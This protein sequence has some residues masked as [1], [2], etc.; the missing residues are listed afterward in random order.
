M[1]IQENEWQQIKDWLNA[2][3][4]SANGSKTH[5][6]VLL[7]GRAHSCSKKVFVAFTKHPSTGQLTLSLRH[8]SV[9]GRLLRAL[10]GKYS[11]YAN[12]ILLPEHREQLVELIKAPPV[13]NQPPSLPPRPPET[14]PASKTSFTSFA[15]RDLLPQHPAALLGFI[16]EKGGT[17]KGHLF[18]ATQMAYIYVFGDKKNVTLKPPF[19][20]RETWNE[21]VNLR[22]RMRSL[23]QTDLDRLKYMV[24]DS[25]AVVLFGEDK[26]LSY[27]QDEE[28]EERTREAFFALKEVGKLECQGGDFSIHLDHLLPNL[29]A[30]HIQERGGEE[31]IKRD[32]Q[33]LKETQCTW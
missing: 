30:Q 28:F 15:S 4:S 1:N 31:R 19:L 21:I 32:Y 25:P 7:E 3:Q 8:I 22:A 11:R 23:P 18:L 20:K 10:F 26:T 6:N 9:L 5:R 27:V 24:S 14:S 2:P 13:Q 17:P 29:V 12:T 16:Q 33:E